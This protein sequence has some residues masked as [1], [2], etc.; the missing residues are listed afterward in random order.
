MM[1]KILLGF[2]VFF[3]FLSSQIKSDD[4]PPKWNWM[5]LITQKWGKPIKVLKCQHRFCLNCLAA[6]FLSGKNGEESQCPACKVNTLKTDISPSFDLLSLHNLLSVSVALIQK[7]RYVLRKR[8]FEFMQQIYRGTPMPNCDFNKVALQ[9]EIT[10]QQE[11]SPINL[12]R[13]FGT[14]LTKNTSG[15]LLLKIQYNTCRKM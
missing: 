10:L 13:I 2:K 11:C 1:S 3:N 4:I 14:P 5:M 7:P 12:L 8:C 9:I 6:S 15:Q